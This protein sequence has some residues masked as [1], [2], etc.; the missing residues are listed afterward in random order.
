M[1]WFPRHKLLCTSP[2]RCFKS[3]IIFKHRT[4]TWACEISDASWIGA[5]GLAEREVNLL[6][7]THGA[8]ARSRKNWEIVMALIFYWSNLSTISIDR[9]WFS[10]GIC[11]YN[12]INLAIS[13]C[14]YQYTIG[15]F[16]DEWDVKENNVFWY[17]PKAVYRN[18]WAQVQLFSILC[19]VHKGRNEVFLAVLVPTNIPLVVYLK[20]CQTSWH[21]HCL[22]KD[23]RML[24]FQF[25]MYK[26]Y[27][28]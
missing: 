13:W 16:H 11:T 10:T 1:V 2:T 25:C 6:V 3:L 21:L 28:F 5:A 26:N 19:T 18:S 24:W 4:V 12:T 23:L 17:V 14:W 20:R 9:P 7:L 15:I 8:A 22:Y 27:S